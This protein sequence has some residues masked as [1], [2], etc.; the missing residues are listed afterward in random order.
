M[1][2]PPRLAGSY[3]NTTAFLIQVDRCIVGPEYW[4]QM[5]TKRQL[6]I[7]IIYSLKYML[8]CTSIIDTATMPVIYVMRE[9][10][11]VETPYFKII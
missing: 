3:A 1:S 9:W 7:K 4:V 11:I 2:G 8:Y 5:R 6:I 10:N